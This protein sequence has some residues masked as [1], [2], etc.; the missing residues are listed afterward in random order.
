MAGLRRRQGATYGTQNLRHCAAPE[1]EGFYREKRGGPKRVLDG[2]GTA[3]ARVARWE[4]AMGISAW[5]GPSGYPELLR[6][7]SRSGKIEMRD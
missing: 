3:A 7:S 1:Q 2:A 4:L 5:F 6:R